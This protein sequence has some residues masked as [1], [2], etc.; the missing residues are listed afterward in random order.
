MHEDPK[1][2]F[3]FLVACGFRRHLRENAFLRGQGAGPG[4]GEEPID[5]FSGRFFLPFERPGALER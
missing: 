1:K 2:V 4:H 3:H 5:P